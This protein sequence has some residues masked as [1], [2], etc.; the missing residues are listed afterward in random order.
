MVYYHEIYFHTDLPEQLALETN[1]YPRTHPHM[2]RQTDNN[3]LILY[4]YIN[5]GI[6]HSFAYI[7]PHISVLGDQLLNA[8]TK[9]KNT[10]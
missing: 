9:M 6:L 4:W 8:I 2:D 1:I 5:I 3:W 7:L 10:L